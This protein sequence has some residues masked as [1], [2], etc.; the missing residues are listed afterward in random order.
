MCIDI[1]VIQ[2][3]DFILGSF[4]H[5]INFCYGGF[6]IYVRLNI[7]ESQFLHKFPFHKFHL[8]SAAHILPRAAGGG[9]AQMF[10]KENAPGLA[11]GW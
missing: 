3:P 7:N 11:G 1:T 5:L 2:F 10:E 9:Q 4:K 6:L 8:P